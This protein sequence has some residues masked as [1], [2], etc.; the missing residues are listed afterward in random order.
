MLASGSFPEHEAWGNATVGML[1]DVL[2]P[3]G[4]I[5]APDSA[6]DSPTFRWATC[7]GGAD[8]P[9]SAVRVP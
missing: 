7:A 9:E 2:E 5:G 4:I 6:A 1:L 3:L 8:I